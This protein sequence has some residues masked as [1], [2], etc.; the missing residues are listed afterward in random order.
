MMK[1]PKALEISKL[2]NDC[3]YSPRKVGIELST[4]HR[5]LQS[6][7][8]KTAMSFFGCLAENYEKGWYD[9]RNEYECKCAKIMIDAL[10]DAGL[11]HEEFEGRIRHDHLESLY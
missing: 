3:S 9:A 10:K 1:N 5:Y 2:I 8:G 7:F 6:E 4:D 11:W